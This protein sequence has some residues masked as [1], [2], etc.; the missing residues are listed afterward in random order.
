MEN[1]GFHILVWYQKQQGYYRD[2]LEIDRLHYLFFFFQ[3]RL[4]E[5]VRFS[6]RDAKLLSILLLWVL[7]LL[8]GNSE[9]IRLPPCLMCLFC[10]S[11]SKIDFFDG[12][13]RSRVVNRG[14]LPRNGLRTERVLTT[15]AFCSSA[16]GAHNPIFICRREFFILTR[17]TE[18]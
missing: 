3:N 15:H 16:N 10:F 12:L 11:R 18:R 7:L 9:Q 13:Q 5:F 2:E 17:S 1:E 4:P 6:G 14:V 8:L